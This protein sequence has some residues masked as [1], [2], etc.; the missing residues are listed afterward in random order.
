METWILKTCNNLVFCNRLGGVWQLCK[1]L[2]D[3]R[4]VLKELIG[5]LCLAGV[6]FCLSFPTCGIKV[7]SLCCAGDQYLSPDQNSRFLASRSPFRPH[8]SFYSY[9][10]KVCPSMSFSKIPYRKSKTK[11]K[12]AKTSWFKIETEE[13]LQ[14]FSGKW[15]LTVP[16]RMCSASG[17]LQALQFARKG[18]Y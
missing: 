1:M 17:T 11:P 10:K 8:L 2:H 14:I 5:E 16:H 6:P 3:L 13:F 12:R 7:C 18:V 4:V 9:G 15:K